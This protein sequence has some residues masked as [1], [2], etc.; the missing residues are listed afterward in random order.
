MVDK[1][2]NVSNAVQLTPMLHYVT[3]TRVEER[4]IRFDVTGGN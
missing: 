4:F 1:T 2:T 3:D